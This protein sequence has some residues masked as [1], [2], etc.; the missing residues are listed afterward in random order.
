MV[1]VTSVTSNAR[2][3]Q[4]VVTRY[5]VAE[6]K[7]QLSSRQYRIGPLPASFYP[8]TSSLMAQARVSLPSHHA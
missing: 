4:A 6:P 5:V 1:F 8:K 2:V 3:Y 7:A